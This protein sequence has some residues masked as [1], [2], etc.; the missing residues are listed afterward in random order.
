MSLSLIFTVYTSRLPPQCPH[1]QAPPFPPCQD[2]GISMTG[3]IL[4]IVTFAYLITISILYRFSVIRRAGAE[5]ENMAIDVE[6]MSS[7]KKWLFQKLKDCKLEEDMTQ[8]AK[9]E[10]AMNLRTAETRLHNIVKD[11]G[12]MRIWS[13]FGSTSMMERDNAKE[14]LE[15]ATRHFAFLEEILDRERYA[16]FFLVIAK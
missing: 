14:N 15:R 4:G 6:Y 1:T 8:L 13:W 7:K 3:S 11:L 9:M 5:V 2:S 10:G 12:G 16:I